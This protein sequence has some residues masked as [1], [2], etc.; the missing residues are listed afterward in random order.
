MDKAPS[1]FD[2][3]TFTARARDHVNNGTR[4]LPEETPV[5]LTYN[6]ATHAV[7]MATPA[8][9]EDFAYGFTLT[10]G[11]AANLEDIESV[12][13]VV[14]EDGVDLRI[15]LVGDPADA[16]WERRR[17]L[18]GPLGCGLCG[19]DSI[20]QALRP[21][22]PVADSTLC[23]TPNRIAQA[24]RLLGDRQP[25]HRRTRAVH[26]AGFLDAE[27]G[28]VHAR[29]D[30]GRHNALDKLIGDLW[31]RGVASTNGAL[32][33]TS[34][35]SIEMVQKAAACGC[36]ILIAVSA[37]T[38]LAVRVAD[39]AGI[40]LVATARGDRFEVFTH[41]ERIETEGIAHVS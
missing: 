16:L 38:A 20:K 37:P 1:T 18:A 4:A 25:L 2:S 7:M 23:L 12:E 13:C 15:R 5:A 31:R 19:I 6:G 33:I 10:E 11:I 14:L 34:R 3:V 26:A 32:V 8:N 24:V 9:L 17:V 21:A 29:E 41:P 22:P 28:V 35:V 27:A 40:T 39:T 30:V 36:P